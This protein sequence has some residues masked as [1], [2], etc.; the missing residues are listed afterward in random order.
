MGLVG[1]QICFEKEEEGGLMGGDGHCSETRS[2][3]VRIVRYYSLKIWPLFHI[4]K[5]K[6]VV[7]E[8][9]N[10]QNCSKKIGADFGDLRKEANIICRGKAA[11]DPSV[12]EMRPR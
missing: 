11:K 7:V 1:F 8:I 9:W 12:V 10:N 2:E 3:Q 4:F 5:M 6:I